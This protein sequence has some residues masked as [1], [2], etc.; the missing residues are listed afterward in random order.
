MDTDECVSNHK[1][2]EII[3]AFDL[4]FAD[5]QRLVDLGCKVCLFR[6][7]PYL[8]ISVRYTKKLERDKHGV[9]GTYFAS[10]RLTKFYNWD[11]PQHLYCYTPS[12]WCRWLRMPVSTVHIEFLAYEL[13]ANFKI[14]TT[15][16]SLFANYLVDVVGQSEGCV[17]P[18]GSY[19][20]RNVSFP[21]TI[22]EKELYHFGK[23]LIET[24][25]ANST[26]LVITA[27]YGVARFKFETRGQ[28]PAI[29]T[30]YHFNGDYYIRLP[31]KEPG[32]YSH[33]MYQVSCSVAMG[34]SNIFFSLVKGM[35]SISPASLVTTYHKVGRMAY[36]H[37]LFTD[38]D[39][40]HEY[41]DCESFATPVEVFQPPAL[42][43]K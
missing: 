10:R 39:V 4:S 9:S 13:V 12:Y 15:R 11:I 42:G 41:I 5:Y 14:P 30:V 20:A 18:P 36:E 43:E 32:V 26:G 24:I 7:S 3:L 40:V 29:E 34:Y 6:Y 8:P 19:Y 33:Q 16:E 22:K 17:L 31:D 27:K 28:Y 25:V 35:I 21:V 38:S 2:S 1:R 23:L 37:Q